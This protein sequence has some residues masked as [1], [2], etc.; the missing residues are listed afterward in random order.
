M[1]KKILISG[2]SGLLGNNLAIYFRNKYQVIGSY[3]THPVYIEGVKLIKCDFTDNKAVENIISLYQPD[4]IIHCVSLTDIELCQINRNHAQKLNT[5][6]TK[7]VVDN[8]HDKQI[9]LV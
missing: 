4:I 3:L 5:I 6:T 8:I 1:K 9:K 2:V 7:I